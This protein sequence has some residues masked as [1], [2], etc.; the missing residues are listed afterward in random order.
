MKVQGATVAARRAE[1][2]G[3]LL[4]NSFNVDGGARLADCGAVSLGHPRRLSAMSRLAVAAQL[5]VRC[6][7][8]CRD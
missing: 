5:F 2:L 7:S 3:E 4:R 8:L 1:P 6:G